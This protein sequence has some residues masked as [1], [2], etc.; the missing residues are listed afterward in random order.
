MALYEHKLDLPEEYFEAMPDMPAP[1]PIKQEVVA[2][3]EN[4]LKD[5]IDPVAAAPASRA[6]T[7]K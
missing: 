3:T 5:A 6:K 1:E 7:V 4:P 2:R